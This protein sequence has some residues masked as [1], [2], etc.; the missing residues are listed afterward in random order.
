MEIEKKERRGGERE[1]ERGGIVG[2]TR[3]KEERA[4]SEEGMKGG[5]KQ[6]KHKTGG[7]DENKK[8]SASP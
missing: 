7:K 6:T 4:E 8:F 1:R 3:E 5:R 2:G